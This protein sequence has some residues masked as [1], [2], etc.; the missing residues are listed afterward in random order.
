MCIGVSPPL[1]KTPLTAFLPSPHLNQQTVQVPLFLGHLSLLYWFWFFV[2]LILH[3]GKRMLL[4]DAIAHAFLCVFIRSAILNCKNF[5]RSKM[6]SFTSHHIFIDY[7]QVFRWNKHADI[8]K[9]F[10][11][12]FSL[13]I[14]ILFQITNRSSWKVTN[15]WKLRL[16]LVTL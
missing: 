5:R 16:T 11:T 2:L 14:Y 13:V 7:S 12:F 15:I 10:V 3:H 8:F 9:Y 4:E 6:C 1:S